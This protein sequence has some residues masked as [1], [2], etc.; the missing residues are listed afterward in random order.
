MFGGV[1][2]DG[3]PDDLIV[4]CSKG[5]KTKSIVVDLSMAETPQGGLLES[6]RS[7]VGVQ[8]T[9]NNDEVGLSSC[10][11]D[12]LKAVVEFIPGCIQAGLCWQVGRDYVRCGRSINGED[13]KGF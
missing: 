1:L 4:G 8:I 6:F 7:S 13:G 2:E 12:K 11:Q 5:Q 10:V 3:I 9:G